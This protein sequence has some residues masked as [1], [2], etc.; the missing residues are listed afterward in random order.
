MEVNAQGG[1]FAHPIFWPQVKKKKDLRTQNMNLNLF[2]AVKFEQFPAPLYLHDD[3]K[4]AWTNM[5]YHLQYL[6]VEK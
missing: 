1:P 5:K 3:L 6:G 4:I 2:I